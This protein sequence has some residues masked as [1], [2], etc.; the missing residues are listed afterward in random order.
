[1]DNGDKVRTTGFHAGRVTAGVIV[2]ALG[3]LMLL[4]RNG[5]FADHAMRFFPGLVLVTIGTVRMAEGWR[6]RRGLAG[7]WLIAI[8]GW[9]LISE[10]HLWGLNHDTSWPLL[11]VIAGL[12][13][14]FGGL[15]SPTRGSTNQEQH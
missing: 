1:M 13:I 9:L 11:L 10:A 12:L 15:F 4:Q 14:V 5:Q 2:L 6:R 7:V 3:V 8:G